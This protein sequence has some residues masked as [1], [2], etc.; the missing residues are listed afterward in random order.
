[1]S[2]YRSDICDNPY[3]AFPVGDAGARRVEEHAL[4]TYSVSL[5]GHLDRPLNI[6]CRS[7]P[8]RLMLAPLS[9]I[10]HAA[11]RD[12][13]ARHGGFGLLFSGMCSA[14]AIAG[15]ASAACENFQYGRH[16]L[17]YL[18]CQLF[19]NDSRTLAAAAR[20]VESAGMFGVDINFGCSV[21]AICRRNSGAAL[22]KQPDLAVSLVRAVRRAVGLPLFVKFR[23]GWSD[24]PQFAVDLAR[25]FEDAG[26]DALTFHPRVAPDRRTRRPKWSYIA[27]VKSAVSIPVFGNGN[28]FDRADC[29]R[30]LQTTHCDGV[31]LGRLAIARPWV[32]AEWAGGL[33]P[34]DQLFRITAIELLE[35]LA[36]EFEP[37]TALRRF[38]RFAAYFA[39]N[40]RFGHALHGR[41]CR[42]VSL[43]E[44]RTAFERF[45][46]DRPEIV[47]RPWF[48]ALGR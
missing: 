38:N 5:A 19:G 37:Q 15:G 47:E 39:A 8:K 30:M 48:T 46:D 33:V 45:F 2:E 10:G 7:V 3:K 29:L 34:D 12:I 32:F 43:E 21:N 17:G 1:L 25:R 14:A 41:I 24:D 40:F 35:R 20:R 22:L 16:E 42:S 36:D 13:V 31:A 6:G 23:T 9:K 27:R 44:V 11:F 26:A 28:V 18:V 4:S